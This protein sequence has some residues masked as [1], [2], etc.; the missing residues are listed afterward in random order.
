MNCDVPIILIVFNRPSLTKQ[1]FDVIRQARPRQLFVVADG[2][3]DDVSTD[4][5]RC[6]ETRRIAT[7]VDWT[8]EVMTDFSETNLGC[9]RRPASGITWAFEHVAEAIILE[10]DCVP[11]GSFFRFCI[12]LLA[13]YRDEERVMAISGTTHTDPGMRDAYTYRF[14][15]YPHCWGWAT[16][17]RAW[18]HFD[19]S[20]TPPAGA[21]D[22]G[23]IR[24]YRVF[25]REL[26]YW[27]RL[28]ARTRRQG[29]D[30]WD[31]R[32]MYSVWAHRGL[33]VV[34]WRNLVSNIGFG[35]E[36]THTKEVSA[37]AAMPTV[38]IDEIIHPRRIR[39]DVKADRSA[40]DRVFFEWA[41]RTKPLPRTRP[42]YHPL[43]IA[44]GVRRR[45][46]IS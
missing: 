38:E 21:P 41:A 43:R 8:C 39:Q 14:S 22:I 11:N 19:F 27:A 7:A 36:A 20:M 32:W 18:Q 34:P 44:G 30:V 1:V 4:I 17:R 5:E 42:W 45:M 10:D 2:P 29:T 35:E 33:A 16:W 25:P 3:R 13:R 6:E 9:G 15:K 28:F 12:E 31:Y 26:D 40:Y 23:I 24:N 46:G 37:C